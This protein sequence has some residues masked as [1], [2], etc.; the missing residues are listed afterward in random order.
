MRAL[1]SPWLFFCCVAASAQL[2]QQMP[3]FPGA[4]R[5]DAAS[6]H[7]HGMYSYVGTGRDTAFAYRNDWYVFDMGSQTWAEA[8]TL[9]A[10]GRQYCSGFTLG[11]GSVGFLFGG[12]GENGPLNELWRFDGFTQAWTQAASLPG[13]GRYACTVITTI[14]QAYVCGGLLAGGTPTNEVWRYDNITNAWTQMAPFPGTP[15]H[16]AAGM[17]LFLIGGADVDYQ[18]LSDVFEYDPSNDTW[19]QR[20]DLPQPRFGAVA[21]EGVLVG[22]ASSLTDF[23][24][25]VCIQNWQTDVW[26]V[27]QQ[28]FPGG[29]RRGAVAAHFSLMADVC[30]VYLGTGLNGTTRY[31]DWWRMACPFTSI[32]EVEGGAIT[33]LPNPAT[34][35]VTA[36]LPANW[37]TAAFRIHDAIGRVVRTGTRGSS[38][39][40]PVS[41]L[42]AGRYTLVVE[43]AGRSLRAPFI[44][45]P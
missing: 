32:G 4:P 42:A 36:S 41:D 5:D 13:P 38:E 40:I 45:L 17:G 9:P 14:D 44:K 3:D 18:A 22:G 35:H 8:P 27:G 21:I 25:D 12:T 26:S 28:S 10:S 11:N 7:L 31:N 30:I 43:H 20:P 16:R 19:S 24:A 6:F 29:P 37:S 1:L 39:A 15:R 34:G 33:V 2:W 23:H